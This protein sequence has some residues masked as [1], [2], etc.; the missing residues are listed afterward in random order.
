MPVGLPCIAAYMPIIGLD[1]HNEIPPL[2]PVLTPHLTV[3]FIQ[4]INAA[5]TS[6]VVP[7]V[8]SP[9]GP[10][11]GRN[12]DAAPF[13]IHI[14]FGGWL[15]WP[16]V[17]AMT[18]SKCEWGVGSVQI[19]SSKYP[20]AI[21]LLFV[22]GPQL[23]CQDFPVPPWFTGHALSILN[24]T[25]RAGFTLADFVGSLLGALHDI[26]VGYLINFINGKLAKGA[27][28]L[29]GGLIMRVLPVG[30]AQIAFALVGPF[31]LEAYLGV[32][33][34]L[35]LGGPLGWSPSWSVYSR[36]TAPRDQGGLGLPTGDNAFNWGRG[37]FQ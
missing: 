32:G 14:S 20:T 2:P 15:L 24:L 33:T 9:I 3:W 16:V 27:T 37:L 36:L 4:G 13:V 35:A 1:V 11:V 12:H 18:S 21:G 25:V 8:K 30:A 28:A 17:M 7:T 29:V 6:R 23:H 5:N 22:L 10:L 34:G 26:A 31:F 19:G